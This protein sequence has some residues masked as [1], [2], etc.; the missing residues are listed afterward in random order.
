MFINFVIKTLQIIYVILGVIAGFSCLMAS[1]FALGAPAEYYFN[2]STQAYH[3]ELAQ[4]L[5]AG[6]LICLGILLLTGFIKISTAL[7]ERKKWV[8]KFLFP[9]HSLAALLFI[10][11]L[12][13]CIADIGRD[14]FW[15]FDLGL[16]NIFIGITVFVFPLIFF[17]CRS[18]REQ[19]N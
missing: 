17:L 19:F 15:L 11:N 8:L 7:K 16:Y 14:T 13:G 18:V 6:L 9:L 12:P 1:G 10:V 3:P 2:R 5:Y 4:F